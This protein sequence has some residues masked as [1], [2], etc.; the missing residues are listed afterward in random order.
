LD[1]VKLEQVW[2]RLQDWPNCADIHHL[3][4]A[5]PGA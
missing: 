4:T 2:Q 5:L 1:E 3:F